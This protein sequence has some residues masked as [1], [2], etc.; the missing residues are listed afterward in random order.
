MSEKPDRPISSKLLAT[1]FSDM[2][3]DLKDCS[4][5]ELSIGL[6][7]YDKPGQ[8]YDTWPET[9]RAIVERECKAWLERNP[10]AEVRAITT[11]VEPGANSQGCCVF[12][13]HW[14]VKD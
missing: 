2:I 12:C 10:R 6:T 8:R 9:V 3:V 13:V 4:I 11:A 14:R 1:P 7:E 5:F